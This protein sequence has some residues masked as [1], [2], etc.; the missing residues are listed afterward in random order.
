[1]NKWHII[2]VFVS[3]T[4]I[5]CMPTK[6]STASGNGNAALSPELQ[7]ILGSV[8][9][10]KSKAKSISV[11]NNNGGRVSWSPKGDIILM[12]RKS[13]DGYYDIYMVRPDGS[14]EQCLTCDQSQV[15]G[16]GHIGQ[17]EWHPSGKYI[18]FQVQKLKNQGRPGRDLAAT[19]GFGRHSDLWLMEFDTKRCFILRQTPETE[20]SGVLHPHF[21]H[22]GKKLTWGE[23]YEAPNGSYGYGKW[24]IQVADFNFDSEKPVLTNTKSYEPGKP[25][26]YEN[27]G[28]S[29]DDKKLLFTSSFAFN[30]PFHANVYS[31]DISQDRLELLADGKWNEHALYSPNGNKIV[32]MSGAQ[33]KSGTDYWCMNPDGS[34]KVAITDWNNPSLPTWKNKMIVAADVSFSPDGKRMVAYLQTNLVTQTGVTVMIDLKDEWYK[35]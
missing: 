18:I 23:M 9:S 21:S 15:L 2:S 14:N 10:P 33:N 35:N 22:D 19:P 7:Q 31:Y 12:D 5:A 32:W 4:L 26:W 3:F 29:P 24:K 25:G 8:E 17:P 30:K 20:A 16:K 11:L 1:M 6:P 28:L 13:D 34:G 27:H